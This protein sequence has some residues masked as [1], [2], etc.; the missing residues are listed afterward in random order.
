LLGECLTHL[1]RERRK[2]LV[3]APR[4]A[5]IHFFFLAL[6]FRLPALRSSA[7]IASPADP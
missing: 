2:I 4:E 7:E 5:N 6:V 1:R 3:S